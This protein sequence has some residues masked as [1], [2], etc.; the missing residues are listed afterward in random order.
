MTK[1]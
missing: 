1:H